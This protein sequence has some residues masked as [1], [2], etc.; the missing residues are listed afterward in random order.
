MNPKI[1]QT[2]LST[3]AE[4]REFGAEDFV[5]APATTLGLT[6]SLIEML[7]EDFSVTTV[8]ELYALAVA[9][10][11]V[12]LRIMLGEGLIKTGS[13]TPAECLRARLAP[14]TRRQF[15]Q[16]SRLRFAFGVRH[17]AAKSPST[18]VASLALRES[19]SAAVPAKISLL[20]GS[21]PPVKN[22]QQRPTCVA[23]ATCALLEYAFHRRRQQRLDLSEQWQ[24]WNC[25]QQDGQPQDQGTRLD[26]SFDL[27]VR[28]GICGEAAWP[29]DPREISG[30]E[31]HGPPPAVARTAPKHRA[32]RCLELDSP[33][34]VLALKQRLAA[35]Q[36]VAFAI[37]VFKSWEENL[38]TRLTGNILMPWDATQPQPLD[39]ALVMVGYANDRD[40]AGGGYFII[41]NC[42]GTDWGSR[43]PFGAGYGT[44]PYLF[45][46]QHNLSAFVVEI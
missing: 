41:R 40:F 31:S 37:P 5:H 27:A 39:H 46:E 17:T 1:G 32:I 16:V 38:N 28:D 6:P 35:D 22:Q 33:Q 8:E 9:R 14:K 11:P 18:K 10:D 26:V 15:E 34:N 29:Y 21:M 45:I 19:N 7:A 20:N 13:A 2:P 42:W 25:K 24:Y 43:S 44:I 3:L 30:N 36:P 23:F 12:H 4:S